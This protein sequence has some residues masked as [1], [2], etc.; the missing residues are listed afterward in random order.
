MNKAEVHRLDMRKE[1][2][3]RKASLGVVMLRLPTE[4][5]SA[6]KVRTRATQRARC[7]ECIHFCIAFLAP[8]KTDRLVFRRHAGGL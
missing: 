4:V 5:K 8:R 2:S 3:K 7:S 6:Q 1:E